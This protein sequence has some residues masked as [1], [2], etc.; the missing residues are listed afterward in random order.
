MDYI[1]WRR[2]LRIF[3]GQALCQIESRR[4]RKCDQAVNMRKVISVGREIQT[5]KTQYAWQIKEKLIYI[6]LFLCFVLTILN[7]EF[8]AFGDTTYRIKL[9]A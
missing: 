9:A 1:L 6:L 2:F 4:K 5:K 3:H 8:W 7:M